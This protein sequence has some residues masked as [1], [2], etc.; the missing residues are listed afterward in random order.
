MITR[1]LVN[2]NNFSTS[3]ALAKVSIGMRS[4]E[5]HS[6]YSISQCCYVFAF[7]YLSVRLSVAG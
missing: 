4:T 2:K 5:C 3:A 6:G 7:V 1:C